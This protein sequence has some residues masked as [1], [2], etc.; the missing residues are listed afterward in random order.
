MRRQT[1]VLVGVDG[2]LAVAALLLRVPNIAAASG[3]LSGEDP[4]G[5]AALAAAALL[6]WISFLAVTVVVLVRIRRHVPVRVASARVRV[7]LMIAAGV[8]VLGFGVVRHSSDSYSMC[9]GS[10]S[11]ARQ[12]L[13]NE[14]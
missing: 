13:A 6:I 2:A 1:L 3:F 10:I 14:P 12:Q 4:T 9:C 8:A 11:Q 7:G 5:V